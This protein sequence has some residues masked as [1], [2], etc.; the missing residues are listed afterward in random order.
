[1]SL[2]MTALDAR[3]RARFVI[4]ADESGLVRADRS[5]P[6]PSTIYASRCRSSPASLPG[7]VGTTQVVGAHRVSPLP[8][9]GRELCPGEPGRCLPA[10]SI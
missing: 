10:S 6:G 8:F 5:V 1:V 2:A 7:R 4:V 9:A 3:S